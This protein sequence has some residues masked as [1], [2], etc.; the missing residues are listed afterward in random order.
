MV[1]KTKTYYVNGKMTLEI[2][3]PIKAESL[4]DAL[5]AAHSLKE[6]DFVTIHGDFNDG[7]MKIIDVF[8][9]YKKIE[10]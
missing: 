7:E 4:K 2:C 1:K 10:L 6:T 5:D 8:E 9:E 3:I